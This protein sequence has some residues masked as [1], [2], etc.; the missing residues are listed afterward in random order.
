MAMPR[1]DKSKQKRPAK[2]ERR[3]SG[4]PENA[5]PIRKS[6]PHSHH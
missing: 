5:Q 6:G 2:V 1:N 3:G 4:K